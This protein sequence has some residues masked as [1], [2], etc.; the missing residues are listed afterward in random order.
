LDASALT[1]N[2]RRLVSNVAVGKDAGDAITTGVS[3]TVL[4][5]DAAGQLTTGQFNACVGREVGIQ[6]S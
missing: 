5:A 4:G 1:A 2:Y 6:F 3:N